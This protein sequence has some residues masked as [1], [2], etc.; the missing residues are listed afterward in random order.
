[1]KIRAQR[2]EVEAARKK[3]ERRNE[4]I[5]KETKKREVDGGKHKRRSSDDGA[6]ASV[7]L[8]ARRESDSKMRKK[9][10]ALSRI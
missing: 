1:M 5:L 8:P 2:K 4:R 6:I 3:E 10:A 9:L 7:Q